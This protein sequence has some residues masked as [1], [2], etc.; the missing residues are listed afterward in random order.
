MYRKMWARTRGSSQW[1][2]GRIFRSTVLRER[3]ARSTP[4]SALALHAPANIER[5]VSFR[6]ANGRPL[7]VV[8]IRSKRRFIGE[9][10][11]LVPTP[12]KPWI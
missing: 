4:Q 9:F 3:K 5:T 11:T 2:I 6:S 8:A 7:R 1:W 10:K 12:S